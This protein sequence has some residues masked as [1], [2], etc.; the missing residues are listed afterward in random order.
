M[1]SYVKKK[2]DV[3]NKRRKQSIVIFHAR[4]IYQGK[5]VR[6]QRVPV[7]AKGFSKVW[8]ASFHSYLMAIPAIPANTWFLC[9]TALFPKL[10]VLK[11]ENVEGRPRLSP[12][13]PFSS[14]RNLAKRQPAKSVCRSSL[15]S[16]C[17]TWQHDPWAGRYFFFIFIILFV[18]YPSGLDYY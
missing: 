7:T 14:N 6:E 12:P 10:T 11:K 1:S 5:G 15:L 4:A 3:S 13:L 2:T 8:H 17:C 18:K 16:F 9:K